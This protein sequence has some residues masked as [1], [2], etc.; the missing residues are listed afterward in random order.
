MTVGLTQQRLLI[1][2]L[3]SLMSGEAWA[4]RLEFV[5]EALLGQEGIWLVPSTRSLTS[6]LSCARGLCAGHGGLTRGLLP[7]P[8][9][10]GGAAPSLWWVAGLA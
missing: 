6:T 3:V 5:P 10:S 8:G 7:S 2:Y 9:R 1:R 4:G